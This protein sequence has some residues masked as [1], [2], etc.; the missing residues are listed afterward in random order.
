MVSG[1][2]SLQQ[3]THRGRVLQIFGGTHHLERGNF[4]IYAGIPVQVLTALE[5][6]YFYFVH[7]YVW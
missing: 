5:L 7:C 3:R 6:A 1:A 4:N 2:S